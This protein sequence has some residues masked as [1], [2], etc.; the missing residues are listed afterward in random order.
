[1]PWPKGRAHTPEM[2]AKRLMT[3]AKNG[4]SPSPAA[5]VKI[6]LANAGPRN[7]QWRGGKRPSESGYIRAWC[8]DHPRCDVDGYVFEHRLVMEAHLGRP[9]LPTEVVHHING[10]PSDNRIE[11]L[12]LF[13]SQA[14]HT[15]FHNLKTW[16]RA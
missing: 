16:R 5:R 12:S 3:L 14:K 9:L 6:S 11:N 2:I 1:M 15:T 7:G 10:I 4:F 13:S 8:P